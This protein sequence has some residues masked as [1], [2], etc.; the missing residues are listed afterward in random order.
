M[1]ENKTK[2]KY[3]KFNITEKNCSCILGSLDSISPVIS[4]LVIDNMKNKF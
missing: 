3:A 1:L 2:M 4:E